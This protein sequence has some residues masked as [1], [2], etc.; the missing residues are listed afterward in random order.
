LK[1]FI[2]ILVF[3]LMLFAGCSNRDNTTALTENQNSE[4]SHAYEQTQRLTEYYESDNSAGDPVESDIEIPDLT[5][6]SY[7]IYAVTIVWG[8]PFPQINSPIDPAEPTVWDGTLSMNAVGVVDINK[9]I[10]FEEAQDSVLPHSIPSAVSWGATTDGDF[11]G[12]CAYVFYKKG[13]EY[14]VAPELTFTTGPFT[15]SYDFGQ[16]E[17][18]TALYQVD[19]TN[20]VVVRARKIWT[21]PCPRGFLEGTWIKD[22]VLSDSGRFEGLWIQKNSDTLGYY[23][24]RFQRNDDGTGEFTGSVSGYFTDQV[25]AEFS[26]NWTYDDPRMCPLC[27]EGHGLFWGTYRY[28]DRTG[29]GTMR[30]VFGD[31]SLPP[32][33][34]EM[35]MKG[36]WR[37]DCDAV[38]IGGNAGID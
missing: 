3:S 14:F 37:D 20:F 5:D 7:D 17:D 15:V 11:D 16:L 19:N 29:T 8:W 13:I 25:I 24:G 18:F 28:L 23:S 9:T 1:K 2:P 32:N 6:N 21:Y 30:G 38:S 34:I 36:Y 35:P 26:G 27:G 12:F 31:Y 10:S 22:T 33:D 4:L